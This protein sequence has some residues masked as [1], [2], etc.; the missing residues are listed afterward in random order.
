MMQ[1]KGKHLI[2]SYH[3]TGWYKRKHLPPP[4]FKAIGKP[5]ICVF[6]CNIESLVS[7]LNY[8]LRAVKSDKASL[9]VSWL[10]L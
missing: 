3:N 6:L 10:V 9:G 2:G 5:E 7:G 8:T 1:R 4:A